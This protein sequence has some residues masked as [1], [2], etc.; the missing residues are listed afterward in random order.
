[1]GYV[2]QDL[3]YHRL[4]LYLLSLL[5][6]MGVSSLP[7]FQL[8]RLGPH[9]ARIRDMLLGDDPGKSNDYGCILQVVTD[10]GTRIPVTRA[11][12]RHRVDALTV[13]YRLLIDGLLLIWPV[14]PDA[15]RDRATLHE[16]YLQEDGTWRV[17][18]QRRIDIP[19]LRESLA[20]AL[21]SRRS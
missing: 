8:I 13:Q 14:G 20:P 5:W 9:E 3:D 11:P 19:F 21:R 6:R 7:E 10:G 4:K 12:D 2:I 17:L 15:V 1:L 16:F 18:A